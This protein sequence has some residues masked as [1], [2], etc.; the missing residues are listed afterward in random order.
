M[1]GMAVAVRFAAQIDGSRN[2]MTFDPPAG[3]RFR[4]MSRFLAA[5]FALLLLTGSPQTL[6]A[7]SMRIVAVV[8]DEMISGY[9]LDQRIRLLTGGGNLPNSAEQ[10]NRLTAQVLRSMVDERLQ[11]QE[12]KRLN[13]RVE[14]KEID[15]ALARIEKQNDVPAGQLAERLKADGMNIDTLQTQVQAAIAWAKVVRRRGAR[16]ATVADDEIDEALQRIKENAGKPSHLISQIFLPVDSPQEENQVLNNARRLFDELRNGTPFTAL[17]QQFSQDASARAGGDMGWLQAGQMP[18]EVENVLAQMPIGSVSQPV[19]SAE[20]Y[21]IVALRNRREPQGGAS[22]G[23]VQVSLH[24]IVVPLP[25]NA[26]AD[27]AAG[28]RNLAQTLSETLNGC[29]DMDKA[30][31]EMGSTASGG[32]GLLRVGEM[33]PDLRK[34][35]LGLKVGQPSQPIPTEGGLRVLMVCERQDPPSNLPDRQEIQRTLVEQKLEL[36]ARRLLRDLRQTAFVDI[37]A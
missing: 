17:A 32:T 31:K 30:A 14:P 3:Y 28:Q 36:Q 27:E 20:G 19:R 33:A 6:V 18:E 23:D 34:V 16:F 1:P 24:Q 2:A 8:N 26:G 5:S 9:D 4:V 13:I 35:V 12:A 21:H 25:A 22:E 7:Q 11:M 29:D 10:R 15:E 37:R